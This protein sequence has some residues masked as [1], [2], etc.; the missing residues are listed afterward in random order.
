MA[1]SANTG[2]V[3][4]SHQATV[5]R[6]ALGSGGEQVVIS[7]TLRRTEAERNASKILVIYREK[8]RPVDL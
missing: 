2:G 1:I 5:A 4:N 7:R 6:D 3:K 8:G